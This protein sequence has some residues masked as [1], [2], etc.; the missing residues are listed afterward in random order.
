MT[1]GLHSFQF[2][3]SLSLFLILSACSPEDYNFEP[4][5]GSTDIAITHFSYDKLVFEGEVFSYDMMILPGG[6]SSDWGFDRATHVVAASDIQDQI[7]AEVKR[8]IIG[9]GLHGEGALDEGAK[10]LLKEL[11]AKGVSTHVLSTIDA[12][13]LFNRS[14]KDGLLTFIHVRN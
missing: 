13:Q 10:A 11:E 6:K 12:A 2:I 4:P 8:V 5:K 14:S 3:F 9:T 7:T 1:F